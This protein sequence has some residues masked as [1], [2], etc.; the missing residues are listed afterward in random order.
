[1]PNQPE[2]PGLFSGMCVASEAGTRTLKLLLDSCWILF[3]GDLVLKVPRGRWQM[4]EQ[5]APWS[6]EC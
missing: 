6:K 4:F 1:M 5:S 3:L 2:V